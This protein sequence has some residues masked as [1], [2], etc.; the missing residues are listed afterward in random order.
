MTRTLGL[1]A[2]A[3]CLLLVGEVACGDDVA[4]TGIHAFHRHGQTCP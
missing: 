2:L 3:A 1:G 4:V